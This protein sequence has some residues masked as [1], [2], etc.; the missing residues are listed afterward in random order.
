MHFFAE[1]D[2]AY[3]CPIGNLAQEMGDLSP[4]FRD[5]LKYALEKWLIFIQNFFSKHRS[6]AR[7][8]SAW[9]LEKPLNSW[10]AAGTEPLST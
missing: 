6:W 4:E 2:F 7:Y 3:G 9:M 8:P 1:E 5:K 10:S